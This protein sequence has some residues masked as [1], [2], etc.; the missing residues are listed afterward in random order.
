MAYDD[1][2]IFA[3]ILRGEI[4]CNK[5]Y[6]DDHVLAFDLGDLRQQVEVEVLVVGTGDEIMDSSMCVAIITA[7]PRSKQARTARR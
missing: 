7:R 2:N 1:S 3:R 6:E 5:V 4:P